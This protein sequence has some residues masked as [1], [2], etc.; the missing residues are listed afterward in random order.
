MNIS[1]RNIHEQRIEIEIDVA[2]RPGPGHRGVF[3]GRSVICAHQP[4]FIRAKKPDGGAVETFEIVGGTFQPK[5]IPEL[6]AAIR[7]IECIGTESA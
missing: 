7:A 5:D 1:R 4:V 3:I 2:E 6:L